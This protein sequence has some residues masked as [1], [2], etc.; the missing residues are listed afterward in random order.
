MRLNLGCGS[1]EARR[2]GQRRQ[3]R[4]CH[5]RSSRRSRSTTV[6]VARRFRRRGAAV[7]RARASRRRDGCLFG[8]YQGAVSRLSRR[9]Q[10]H[11]CRPAS[12]SRS[13]SQRSNTCAPDH[14]GKH[15]RCSRKPPI[16]TG[17]PPASPI[18]HWAFIS[19]STLSSKPITRCSAEPWRTRLER[20]EISETRR[21]AGCAKFQQ[22]HS[23]DRVDPSCREAGRT[24]ELPPAGKPPDV[25][26]PRS[27]RIIRRDRRRRSHR[28]G[29]HGRSPAH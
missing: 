23:A 24:D 7:A 14:G 15:R 2:L 19:A 9:C 4:G 28:C 25:G 29:P 13:L 27:L 26:K 5:P 22:C 10:N 21:Q 1:K 17:L 8:N 11:N 16:G 20:K 3:G 12:A 18:R 6:A